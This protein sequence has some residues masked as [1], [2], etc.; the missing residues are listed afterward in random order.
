MV[1]KPPKLPSLEYSGQTRVTLD[2]PGWIESSHRG[3][4]TAKAVMEGK[5]GDPTETV[6]GRSKPRETNL[7]RHPKMLEILSQ[8]DYTTTTTRTV[9]N[10]VRTGFN[11]SFQY[12]C[13]Q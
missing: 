11:K 12:L 5:W 10:L 1:P 9:L 2:R 8:L 3:P 6:L 7:D 13:P 4:I